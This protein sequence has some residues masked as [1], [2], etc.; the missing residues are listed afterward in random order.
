MTEFLPFNARPL[1]TL[2]NYSGTREDKI[3]WI[4]TGWRK[5]VRKYDSLWPVCPFFQK[6][7]EFCDKIDKIDKSEVR[8]CANGA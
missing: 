4:E 1:R 5:L 3:T 7:I 6:K 8:E 2:K